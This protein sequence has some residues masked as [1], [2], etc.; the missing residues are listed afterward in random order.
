MTLKSAAA[1]VGIGGGGVAEGRMAG[2]VSCKPADALVSFLITLPQYYHLAPIEITP[3]WTV[4]S[5]IIY[6]RSSLIIPK[7][8]MSGLW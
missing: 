5:K 4:Q 3:V 8:L 1:A 6:Y 2:F 7:K